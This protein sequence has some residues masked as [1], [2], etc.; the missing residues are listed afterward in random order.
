MPGIGQIFTDLPLV[1]AFREYDA[2]FSI[3]RRRFVRPNFAEIRHILNI[4]Q[5][6]A[7]RVYHLLACCRAAVVHERGCVRVCAQRHESR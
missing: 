5:V 4:A 1:A 2:H 6:R 3:S 7:R